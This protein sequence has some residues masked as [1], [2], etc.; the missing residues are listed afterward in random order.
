VALRLALQNDFMAA[1]AIAQNVYNS[2]PGIPLVGCVNNVIG[3]WGTLRDR[4]ALSIDE[5]RHALAGIAIRCAGLEDPAV[6]RV[7][8]AVVTA[9]ALHF[10]SLHSQARP[11][12]AENIGFYGPAIPSVQE[13]IEA[14]VRNWLT[15]GLHASNPL[16]VPIPAPTCA[17]PQGSE[18]I[19]ALMISNPVAFCPTDMQRLCRMLRRQRQLATESA[20]QGT[21]VALAQAR[22]VCR[23]LT[24]EI[25][26]LDTILRGR[27]C[28]M[29]PRPLDAFV[30]RF[31]LPLAFASARAFCEAIATSPV[32]AVDPVQSMTILNVGGSHASLGAA[33]AAAEQVDPICH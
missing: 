6:G 27:L 32:R 31:P 25:R 5:T 23:V 20:T 1:E 10:P 8:A 2:A 15:S 4:M 18:E 13:S 12:L 9:S 11:I 14:T 33:L 28:P 16:P 21:C 29:E 17:I 26:D 19:T 30:S 22:A 7:V 3:A 24:L